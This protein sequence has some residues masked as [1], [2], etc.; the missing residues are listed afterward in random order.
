MPLS[1]DA[2]WSRELFGGSLAEAALRFWSWYKNEFFAFFSPAA[3]AWLLDR[4]DRK[5]V[6]ETSRDSRELGL[7]GDGQDTS[8]TRIAL[9]EFET[10]SLA[11]ALTRRGMSREA[12]KIVLE[13][14]SDQFFVRRFDIPAAARAN[15]P[16]LLIGEIERKTPFRPTDVFFGHIVARNDAHP[17]KLHVEQWILRRDIVLRALEGAGLTIDDLDLVQPVRQ[18]S[19]AEVP[20][21][22]VG[23]KAEASNWFRN[24]AIGL[25][26]LASILFLAGLTITIWR[27]DRLSAELDSKIAEMS[28]RAARV[29]HMADEATGESA[30]LADLRQERESFPVLADL[31]EEIS[32]LLPD[33][34]YVTELRLSETKAGER[35]LDLNGFSDSAAGLPALFDQSPL[36]SDAA[37]T[38][39]ITPDMQEKRERFALQAKV[40]RRGVM[41]SK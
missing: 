5:L 7:A 34:A 38:A 33:G 20:A 37:L 8:A 36:F 26:G 25:G 15:L 6:I 16:R 11:A 3:L 28:A 17:E 32:R 14:A 29:R 21:I 1:P 31:W 19:A 18:T 23:R 10:T 4:G 27:Q 41:Q 13:I 12:T 35:V 9:D 30:L 39:A 22:A 40:R 2:F 24:I